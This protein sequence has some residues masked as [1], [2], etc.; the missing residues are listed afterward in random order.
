MNNTAKLALI[1]AATVSIAACSNAST[2]TNSGSADPIV[3]SGGAGQGSEGSEGGSDAQASSSSSGGLKSSSTSTSNNTAKGGSASSGN[4]SEAGGSSST[5][6]ATGGA[7]SS[8]TK[9]AGGASSSTTKATGG[10]S[11]STTNATGGA[12]TTTSTSTSTLEKFSFFVTSYAAM[13]ALS[14]SELG[15]GGDLRYNLSTGLEGADK[16]CSTIAERSMEGASAKG[17]KAFISTSTVN[18]IDRITY[19]GPYYDR[20]GRVVATSKAGLTSGERPAGADSAIAND[21]P[22][23]DGTANHA[24][25]GVQVDNHD[26]LTGSTSKGAKTGFW[27][28]D[29]TSSTATGDIQIGHSWP[30][31]G[32]GWL[33]AHTVGG[34]KPGVTFLTNSSAESGAQGSVGQMGGY[35]AIYCIASQP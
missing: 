4:T 12:G 22:N 24:P 30:A 29:W 28:Q 16:I 1:A 15:F 9:A 20:R 33:Q 35:G 18:A 25:D 23:E 17:W 21:L 13:K 3:G 5:T 31:H 8:T 7:S 32:N 19:T 27:C 14:G 34:C 11:S 6:K 10:T 26:V 2:D